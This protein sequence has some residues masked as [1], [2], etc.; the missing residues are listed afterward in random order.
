MDLRFLVA[1][2]FAQKG[3]SVLG[4]EVLSIWGLS[5]IGR[6]DLGLDFFIEMR[7]DV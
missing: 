5:S 6:P 7:I 3:E 1:S 2:I 4:K